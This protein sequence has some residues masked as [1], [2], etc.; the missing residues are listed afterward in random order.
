LEENFH[1]LRLSF[2][3]ADRRGEKMNQIKQIES[4]RNF[5]KKLS[6]AAF[7]APF[8]IGCKTIN[9]DDSADILTLIR[10]NAKPA[11]TEG[12]GAIDMPNKVSWQTV[13]SKETDEGEPIII[14]GTIFQPDGKTPAPD[15]LIYFYHTDA[16]GIYGRRGE[17]KH[18]RF[19]GWLLTDAKGRYEFRTIKPAPYPNAVDPAHIHF[20]LTGKNF[21][22]D[23]IDSIWFEG[24]ERI[25]NEIRKRQLSGRGGFNPILKLEKGADGILRGT[26]DIQ[27]WKV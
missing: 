22:E 17:P 1:L 2:N 9:A 26:R 15:I 19:R 27:L 11:G 25:T 7:T 5:L 20:T 10:K 24:D 21:K 18:G 4:R 13:L 12:M 6:F 3:K 8:L 23:W 14:S 16:K